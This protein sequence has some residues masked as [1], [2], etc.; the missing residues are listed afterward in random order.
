M[1]LIAPTKALELS[2]EEN[3]I[4]FGVKALVINADAHIATRKEN[5][6]LWQ[7]ARE[8][9]LILILSPEELKTN[10]KALEQ[11]MENIADRIRLYNSLNWPSYNAETLEFL[12][13][14]AEA[15]I[16][17]ATDVLSVGWDSKNTRDA[18]I[19]GE[20]DD[21]DEFVQKIGR[22]GRNLR[23]IKPRA[24]LYFTS[25]ALATAQ[26]VVD[27]DPGCAPTPSQHSGASTKR[28]MDISMARLLLAECKSAELDN[29]YENPINTPCSCKICQEHPPVPKPST[30]N[31][32]GCIP[33][34][35]TQV[36][37]TETR[38]TSKPRTKSRAKP[39]EGISLEMKTL[40]ETDLKVLRRD[41][42]RS[43]NSPEFDDIPPY[44]FLPEGTIKTLVKSTYKLDTLDDV[45]RILAGNRYV[46]GFHQEILDRVQRLRPVFAKKR[47][48]AKEAK[49]AKK[50]Q[51]HTSTAD[52][53]D[54]ESE[55]EDSDEE[56]FESEEYFTVQ[57]VSPEA[58][59]DPSA[60]IEIRHQSIT[61]RINPRWVH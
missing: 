31:C 55:S 15:S 40:G 28:S 10:E 8:G 53:L 30:C 54:S 47:E 46:S 3:M 44:E 61:W 24:F 38:S 19:L 5:R 4:G 13:N 41:I 9:P 49:A 50:A 39:G 48:E 21:V 37:S 52:S 23:G 17:I 20:P 35:E 2:M 34:T 57:P 59:D 25:T 26:A 60:S 22:I 1:L 51:V 11:K 18:I 42:F 32:S 33:E 27:T 45:A 29:L 56:D 43:V 58:E 7:E 6:N 14:N 12:N 16:T 36:S